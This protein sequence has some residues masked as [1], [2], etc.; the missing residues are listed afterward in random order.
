MK[1]ST[2][3]MIMMIGLY[4][5][6]ILFVLAI[7]ALAKNIEEIKNDPILYGMDKHGFNFCTCSNEE[8][9]STIIELDKFRSSVS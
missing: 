7:I 9:Q 8:G 3:R 5:G 6:I 4:L 1:E 2:Y